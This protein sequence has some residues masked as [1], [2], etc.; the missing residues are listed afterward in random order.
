M[1]CKNLKSISANDSFSSSRE[2]INSNFLAIQGCISSLQQS[3]LT[4]ISPTQL[5]FPDQPTNNQ[6]YNITYVNGAW[7]VTPSSGNGS[8][9][10]Y[11][12][13]DGESLTV[14]ARTQHIVVDD[15]ILD[16]G[17]NLTIE[18]SGELVIL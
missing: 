18:P 9:T 12:L 11:H 7:I 8:G 15:M 3:I 14:K 6:E 1:D 4:S 13:L 5:V 10:K 16:A 17:S 2:K